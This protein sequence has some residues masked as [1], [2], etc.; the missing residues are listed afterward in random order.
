M[1]VF[2][3]QLD[4]NLNVSNAY[5]TAN[6]K[7]QATVQLLVELKLFD[8]LPASNDVAGVQGAVAAL[9]NAPESSVGTYY[10]WGAS[11]SVM[12]WLPLMSTNNTTFSV[13]DGA[14][15]YITFVF[16]Y[17]QTVGSN[18]SYQVYLGGSTDALQPSQPV[19]S[20]TSVTNGINSVSLLG[21]GVVQ[22]V[23]TASGSPVPLSSAISLSVYY[24]SNS[25]CADVYTVNERG[26]N[27]IRLYAQIN[28]V[29]V[30]VGTIDSVFGDGDGHKYH[31]VLSG[32]EAGKSYTFKIEDEVGR[33][34]TQTLKVETIT[35]DGAIVEMS[36]QMLNVTF[37]TVVGRNYQVKVCEDLTVPVAQWTVED[38]SQNREGS[39]GSLTNVFMAGGSQTQIR[40]P[41]NKNKAFFKIFMLE[42]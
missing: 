10:V 33:V 17:P 24:A 19:G 23:G 39:W 12:T 22:T 1:I 36:M 2:E 6:G 3:G 38:V 35:I 15:N 8:D 4:V 21:A 32:L 42:E 25:V 9:R 26:T 11:N 5:N 27:P 20:L 40:I 16:N 28:G 31:I 14:T 7:Y 34:Y 29:W 30:L 18:V 13:N 41:V 37:N